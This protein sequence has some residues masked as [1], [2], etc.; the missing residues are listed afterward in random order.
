MASEKVISSEEFSFTF[1][2][3]EKVQTNFDP[4]T[5]TDIGSHAILFVG[6][7]LF[8]GRGIPER[9]VLESNATAVCVRSRQL[10]AFLYK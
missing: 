9:A 1:S 3:T 5:I 10:M 8:S 7:Y 4:Q 6:N 2:G